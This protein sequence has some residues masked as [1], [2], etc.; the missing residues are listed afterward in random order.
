MKTHE[1][2]K[3]SLWQGCIA[4]G[5]A[6]MLLFGASSAPILSG[7][8]SCQHSTTACSALS[9]VDS[10]THP[11][12]AAS[13]ADWPTYLFNDGRAGY[14]GA[15]T[16]LPAPLVQQWATPSTTKG[17]AAQPMVSSLT[18]QPV[19]YWDSVDGYERAT[20]T[21]NGSPLQGFTPF[22]LGETPYCGGS[23]YVQ[24]GVSTAAVALINGTPTLFVGGANPNSTP[25]VAPETTLYALNA[26]TG[27]LIWQQPTVLTTTTNSY[28]FSSPVVYTPSGAADPSVYIGVAAYA[29]NGPLCTV[30]QGQLFQVDATNG[31]IQ[32]TFNVVPNGCTGGGIWGSPAIDDTTGMLYI[33]TGNPNPKDPQ[34]CLQRNTCVPQRPTIACRWS[35]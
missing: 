28:I 34:T 27:T 17:I 15:E 20:L 21:T 13:G 2:I 16:S 8:P 11:A 33:A 6:L 26:A 29:E 7:S 1:N 3:R 12:E 32:H 19:V 25:P 18:G 14:N 30:V 9:A 4:L 22:Y 23:G 24:A 10:L 5:L 35:N 31:Q